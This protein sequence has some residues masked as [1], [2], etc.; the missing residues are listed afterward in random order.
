M[1]DSEVQLIIDKAEAGDAKAI[2]SICESVGNDDDVTKAL[3]R[4]LSL[5]RLDAEDMNPRVS[6]LRNETRLNAFHKFVNA[7]DY[8]LDSD[9]D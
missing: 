2:M 4:M 7:V 5:A 3:I 1:S 6:R 8:Y 9:N